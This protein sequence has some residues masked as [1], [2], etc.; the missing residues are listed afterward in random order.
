VSRGGG[1][2]ASNKELRQL[3]HLAFPAQVPHQGGA[4]KGGGGGG[5]GGEW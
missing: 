4:A 2:L 3:L 5:M 1:G